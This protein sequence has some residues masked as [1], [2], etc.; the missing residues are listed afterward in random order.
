MFGLEHRAGHSEVNWLS[1]PDGGSG[2]VKPLL[3]LQDS[4]VKLS[5]LK[6]DV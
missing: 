5:I 6:I 4:L 3:Q 2:V 1:L